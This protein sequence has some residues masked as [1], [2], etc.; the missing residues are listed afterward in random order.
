M[1]TT[2]QIFLGGTYWNQHRK[3]CGVESGGQVE[4]EQVAV[5]PLL[6]LPIGAARTYHHLEDTRPWRSFTVLLENCTSTSRL[7]ENT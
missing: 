6:Q 2:D 4:N 1:I 3:W 5:F 7:R